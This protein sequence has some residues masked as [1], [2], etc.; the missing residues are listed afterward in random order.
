MRLTMSPSEVGGT[1]P[2]QHATRSSTGI[3]SAA[4]S[5]RRW[6]CAS[7]RLIHRGKGQAPMHGL[8]I[9]RTAAAV[10]AVV[11]VFMTEWPGHTVVTPRGAAVA[12]A[13]PLE[14][15][16]HIPVLPPQPSPALN[17][18]RSRIQHIVYILKE[19]RSFDNYFGT[20][21]EAEGATTGVISTGEEIPLGHTPD[22][23][24]RDLGH[25]WDDAQRA[26]DSGRMD[27]FDLVQGGNVDG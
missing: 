26:I 12:A 25:G 17:A 6:R 2:H 23:T 20:F 7:V 18:F 8:Q 13:A 21:P 24:G 5:A 10:C 9:M 27:Q 19:N 4:R 3:T 11:A 1:P 16:Q 15:Q 14:Q 22:R